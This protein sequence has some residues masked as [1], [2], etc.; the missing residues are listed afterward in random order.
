MKNQDAEWE[1]M[2]RYLI[3]HQHHWGSLGE[4]EGP[5]PPSNGAL[6]DQLGN[7]LTDQNG[8]VLTDQNGY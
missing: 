8:N 1:R 6:T 4:E 5:P 2:R 3:I 7:L